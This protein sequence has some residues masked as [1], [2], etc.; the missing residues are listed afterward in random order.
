MSINDPIAD[1]LTR[2]RNGARQKFNTV[3]MPASRLKVE[4]L[5]I[6]KREGY[7]KNFVTRKRKAYNILKVYLKYAEDGTCAFE[8]LDRV[9]TPGR[10]VYVDKNTIP[11]VAGGYG[12]AVISTSRGL[13]T[14]QE[15]HKKGVGGEV[16]CRVY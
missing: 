16:L 5:K 6:L 8:K 1:M 11:I 13:L 3:D 14:S 4:V 12:M 2:I 10:R 9:S 7:I 15:A